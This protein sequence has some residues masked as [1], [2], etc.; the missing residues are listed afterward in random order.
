MSIRKKIGD[1]L[2][3]FASHVTYDNSTGKLTINGADYQIKDNSPQLLF[4]TLFTNQHLDNAVFAIADLVPNVPSSVTVVLTFKNKGTAELVVSAM[5]ET[6]SFGTTT[7]DDTKSTV[8]YGSNVQSNESIFIANGSA[9][10]DV[11]L[12][13]YSGD[14]V[15]AIIPKA[16]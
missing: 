10:V 14:V 8:Q 9:E 12:C 2:V 4:S 5:H 7:L 16:G 6:T 1:T 13:I 11:S 3:E 15:D